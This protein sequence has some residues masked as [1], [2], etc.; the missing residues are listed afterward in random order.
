MYNPTVK[1]ITFM[2]LIHHLPAI[3]SSKGRTA[4]RVQAR[5]QA[6]LE[7]LDKH[8]PAAP[9]FVGNFLSIVEALDST[10]Q[11]K[12]SDDLDLIVKHAGGVAGLRKN[13]LD[14]IDGYLPPSEVVIDLVESMMPTGKITGAYLSDS[15]TVCRQYVEKAT[16]PR[17]EHFIRSTL[18]CH[19]QPAGHLQLSVT[20]MVDFLMDDYDP[21]AKQ[22]A[23]GLISRAGKLNEMILERA[24]I[25][26]GIGA[27]GTTYAVTGT[28]SNGDMVFYCSSTI[29]HKQLYAE[30]KSYGARERL[31]R[32]LQ[33]LNGKDAIGVGFFTDASE[34]N[35]SRTQDFINTG[36]L[37]I[38]M[39]DVTYDALH[40]ESKA[41][42]SKREQ[43][44][45]RKLSS[46]PSD[47][48]HFTKKGVL[49]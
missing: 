23:N 26:A 7:E 35:P 12:I 43:P 8:S 5:F 11:G 33:D 10:W 46:F 44:L 17:F 25:N 36:T 20:E 21:F 41:R 15:N 42:Q 14:R 1:E 18:A 40:Q 37:A 34:F 31:L 30:V 45:Y 3:L 4:P 22:V 32:G 47:I 49:P 39:P 2:P 28:K 6:V 29:P 19:I 27:K 24:I 38:Y 48:V 9:V 13:I 16:S